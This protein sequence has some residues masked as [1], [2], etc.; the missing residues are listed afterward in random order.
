[1][2]LVTIAIIKKD[3]KFLIAK[4]KVG[5]VVGGK[6]EFPGGK[7]EYNES[8]QECLKRELKEELNIDAVVGEFFD[9]QLHRYKTGILKILAYSVNQLEGE[10]VLS[11]HDEVRWVEAW[12]MGNFDFTGNNKPL[13]EKLLRRPDLSAEIGFLATEIAMQSQQGLRY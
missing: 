9:Q 10:L 2:Q 12:E 13:V 8:P 1:M 4:R 7:I 5:G 11:E 3:E 6:W